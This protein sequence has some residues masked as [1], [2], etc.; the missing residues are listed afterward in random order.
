MNIFNGEEFFETQG[1]VTIS[2][3]MKELDLN[4]DEW[5]IN[6]GGVGVSDNDT[7]PKEKH[8]LTVSSE[9]KYAFSF[10]VNGEK[11]VTAYK[12]DT[13]KVTTEAIKTDN[14]PK[15]V[16]FYNN[17]SQEIPLKEEILPDP[18][19]PNSKVFIY[20]F[21]MVDY[22]VEMLCNDTGEKKTYDITK[23]NESEYNFKTNPSSKASEGDMITV[24][25]D[26]IEGERPTGDEPEVTVTETTSQE[27][28]KATFVEKRAVETGGGKDPV[29]SY[30]YVYVFL[31]PASSVEVSVSEAGDKYNISKENNL[32]TNPE[33]KAKEGVMVSV[34]TDPI[35]GERQEGE[36][37]EVTV[38][39]TEGGVPGDSK[40]AAYVG[41]RAVDG[42]GGGGAKAGEEVYYEYR[43]AF[44]MPASDVNVTMTDSQ[45]GKHNISKNDNSEYDFTTQPKSK[46]ENGETVMV[47]TDPIEGDREEGEEPEVTVTEKSGSGTGN[48]KKG[49]YVGKYAAPDENEGNGGGA[50]AGNGKEGGNEEGR[51]IYVYVFDM[52][53]SDVEVGVDDVE[54]GG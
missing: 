36:E 41:K 18:G 50:K 37:P 30:E 11:L 20:K 9:N 17:T 52:P 43:Y 35:E 45:S 25:T 3:Q 27:K 44:E 31:M 15:F 12:G 22:E 38:T 26:P 42:E 23:D 13:I 5:C 40:K 48:E 19:K 54:V 32:T 21:K 7:K 47:T 16:I 2:E 33:G 53:D 34:T 51:W 29:V 39:E 10:T 28:Q 4:Q 46:A 49:T 14:T 1:V 8:E 24:T 6:F